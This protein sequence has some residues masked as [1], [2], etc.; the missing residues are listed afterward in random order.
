MNRREF[1]RLAGLSALSGAAIFSGCAS[2]IEQSATSSASSDNAARLSL[3][4][5]PVKLELSPKQSIQT[6]GYNGGAPGPLLR[7]KEGQRVTVDVKNDS[8]VPELVHWHGLYV[9]PEADG[10]MEE[11]TPMVPAGGSRQY[12]FVAR[13]GGTRWYHTHAFAGKDLRRSLY[14]GQ[15]GF[16]YIEPKNNPGKYDQEIFLAAHQWEPEFVSMQDIRKGP[17]PNNGLE[18]MYRAA[19]I[20]D[21]A[22]GHGEPIRVKT[23]E[24]ML[25]HLLNA[26]ATDDVRLALPAHEFHVIALDG[27]AVPNPRG[28]PVLTLAP[29]ER[30]DAI[31]EMKQPGVW[32]LGATDD[33]M[34]EMGMGVVVEY[35]GQ[36]GVPQWSTPQSSNWDY[37]VFGANA[38]HPEPD[39]RINLVFEKIPGGRGGF[40]RWTINGKSWPDVDPLLVKEGQRYRITMD[41]R[42]GDDHPVHFH[43][44]TFELTRIGGKTTAGILKDTVNVPRRQSVEIDFVAD[45]PGLTLYH[46]HMQLHMDFGFMALIKY[47]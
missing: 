44:H 14:S 29:A 46:C 3:R 11:G 8:D 40:N 32:I 39:Q 18:V 26:S 19:S 15:F 36:R 35:A 22:L 10:S 30:I 17:P 24:R 27:N 31:V 34:R 42:S 5:A 37:T 25:V 9:A 6:I 43:R 45:D 21:K 38:A 20:N 33:H 7:V 16:F 23:G 28:V 2:S 12:S 47:A 13:P 4:I 41:N 1:L